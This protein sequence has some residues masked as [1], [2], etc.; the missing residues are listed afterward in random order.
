M[1]NLEKSNQKKLD[2]DMKD[3]LK[4]MLIGRA[5][6]SSISVKMVYNFI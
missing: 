6:N 4:A 5:K 3:F 1:E 2:Q